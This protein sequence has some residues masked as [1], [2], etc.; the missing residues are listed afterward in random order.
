MNRADILI[1]DDSPADRASIKIAFAK[2]GYPL[3]LQFAFS[4]TAALDYL[5]SDGHAR[6]H[7]MLVDV[8]M[9]GFS[10]IE[11]LQTVKR[12]PDLHRIPVIM[13]SGSDD[14][15]DVDSAYR[16]FA[17]GYIRKPTDVEGLHEV[18]DT[19]GKLCTVVLSFPEK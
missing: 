10:G 3:N 18:A 2:S 14:K 16:N 4:G 1:V 7:L 15:E 11:L 19:V 9:P 17:A 12:D 6:P 13:F 8:K 5:R